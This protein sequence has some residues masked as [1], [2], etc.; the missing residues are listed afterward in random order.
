M[1][2]GKSP[3]FWCCINVNPL[4]IDKYL[5]EDDELTKCVEKLFYSAI[6]RSNKGYVRRKLISLLLTEGE[7]DLSR[8]ILVGTFLLIDG[9]L[10][11]ATLEMMQEE[12]AIPCIVNT[13]LKC[14][15]ESIRLRRIFLELTYEVCKVQ[16]LRHQDLESISI[17][18][19]THLYTSIE[20]RDDYDH[21]P[22]GYAIIKVI[23]A[24]NEQYMVASYD[25]S[26]KQD[27]SE[28]GSPLKKSFSYPLTNTLGLH[29]QVNHTIPNKIF[30]TL[31]HQR[32]T[33]RTF[34]ENIVFLLNRSPDDC[35]QLMALKFLYLIFS[36]PETCDCLYLNDL[37][38]IVDVF[39]RELYN[40]SLE[41]ERLRHTYL[42]TLFPLLQNTELQNESYKRAEIVSLLEDMSENACKSV[43]DISE[44]T[45]RLAF[46]CL[47]VDWLNHP[48]AHS[49]RN[50]SNLHLEEYQEPIGAIRETELQDIEEHVAS[51]NVSSF[52]VSTDN[53]AKLSNSPNSMGS[54][55]SPISSNSFSSSLS[56]LDPSPAPNP[57]GTF[58]YNLPKPPPPPPSRSTRSPDSVAPRAHRPAPPPAVP[59]SRGPPPRPLPR[60]KPSLM[61]MSVRN[62][63]VMELA[64]YSLNHREPDVRRGSTGCAEK[65]LPPLPLMPPAPPRPRFNQSH[66]LY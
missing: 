19:V 35:L 9:R 4:P 7:L 51:S 37:K 27:F 50:N 21:D 26:V 44:T 18:F 14:Q 45:Q 11:P 13:L 36:T 6:F 40:L 49:S 59:A 48:S 12:S 55:I 41:E 57:S 46:R 2:L 43:V 39:I 5:A 24:L 15:Y 32:D 25:L 10:N 38:V 20:D 63:S 61:N 8:K 28:H 23:L 16:K 47:Y 56:L 29:S 53:T 34:G 22:Y 65:E 66:S 54:P 58:T 60:K 3:V 33:F 62:T 17:K 30:Q 52:S 64:T 31:V 1:F 42:R